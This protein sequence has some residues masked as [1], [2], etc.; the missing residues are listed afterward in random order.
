M[1]DTKIDTKWIDEILSGDTKSV[2]PSEEKVT[3]KITQVEKKAGKKRG[4]PKVKVTLEPGKDDVEDVGLGEEELLE[5]EIGKAQADYEDYLNSLPITHPE[6]KFPHSFLHTGYLPCKIVRGEETEEP[7]VDMVAREIRENAYTEGK[8]GS[9]VLNQVRFCR[10]WKARFNYVYAGYILTPE[11]QIDPDKF[12]AEITKM[13]FNIDLETKNVDSIAQHIYNTYISAYQVDA[14]NETRKIPFRNGDLYLDKDNKGFTF[15]EGQK[16]AV[17]YRFD[18][19]FV[20]VPNCREPEFPNFKMWR[21]ELFDEEDV[22]TLK[23]ML[24][25]L[26]LPSNEAQ[27]AFFIIGK[28]GS[29]KSILT[30]CVIPEMLGKAKMPI[31]INQFFNDKFQIGT[32]EGKLCMIDDDIG[33]AHLSQDNS[34]R[35]K[36]FVTAQTIKIEH[37]YCNPT[38][39]NNSARIVCAGNHMINSDDKTDGFTR[40]LHPIYVKSRSIEKVDTRLPQ[41]I[42]REI[43]SIVLWAL[44]GLLEVVN[45][46][47]KPYWSD[48]SIQ[49]FSYYSEGQ[50]WEEQFISDMFEYKEGY[51]TYSQDIND[52]LTEWLK[53][54]ADVAGEG[55]LYQKYHAVSRWLKDEGAG[56]YSFTYKRG[57]KR[58]DK[59][60]ARGYVNMA[61]KQPISEP[62]MFTDEH[63]RIKLRIGKRRS[64]KD[65]S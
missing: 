6:L 63:G 30:D 39:I 54:N 34:G 28:A 13:L 47:G 2:P 58:G 3:P 37:K 40:R 55:T 45:A 19:D 53:N 9:M 44:E 41:K 8:N 60:N 61:L 18:Y 46:D 5:A 35:F 42:R 32:S 24:G 51:V 15:Y 29:G 16:S 17:P 59:Y 33:E 23:Q 31:S 49:Q 12:R 38:S 4:R 43:E 27:E 65:D 26:L 52:A 36:N 22:W 25:Y 50:K 56:K 48:R 14:Y 20:N 7:D 64:E 57:I 21:D 62:K 1:T 10:I 11:G